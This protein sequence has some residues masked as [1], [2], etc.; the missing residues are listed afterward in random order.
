[1]KKILRF[2]LI[3]FTFL[4]LANFTFVSASGIN[5][6]LSGNNSTTNSSDE[7]VY[8]SNS[9]ANADSNVTTDVPEN[10]NANSN[11]GTQIP[12]NS[13]A[14]LSSSNLELSTV[15][16]IILIVLGILLILLGIAILIRLR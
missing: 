12:I 13:S 16:N 7:T 14:A 9:N 11:T 6:N 15:I 5:M 10:T 4:V 1:M 2:S 8:G 3:L